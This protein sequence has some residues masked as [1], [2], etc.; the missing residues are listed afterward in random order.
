[1]KPGILEIRGTLRTLL[2]YGL[3]YQSLWWQEDDETPTS[4]LE[5][6]MPIEAFR[7]EKCRTIVVPEP[8]PPAP[9]AIFKRG[10]NELAYTVF[11]PRRR[12][13]RRGRVAE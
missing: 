9:P 10:R 11:R 2:A 12:N 7:C 6:R 5:P 8:P 1:M 4:L 13:A 3:S